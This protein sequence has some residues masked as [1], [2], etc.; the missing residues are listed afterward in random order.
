MTV[1]YGF[2]DSISS[3][4]LYNAKQM[5]SIFDGLIL[6][7][8]Y[9][10]YGNHLKVLENTG[11]TVNVSIGRAWFDHTWTYND[12]LLPKTLVNADALLNRIDIIYLEVNENVGVR[13][14]SINGLTG[15]P[16]SDPVPPDLINTSTIHQY[17][18]A[19]IYVGAGVTQIYQANITD[20]VGT[21]NTPFVA[22]VVQYEDLQEQIYAI[23]GDVN[24]PLI[25]LID[26]KAH[27]HDGSPTVKIPQVPYLIKRQGG[28]A[29]NWNVAGTQPYTPAGVRMQVGSKLGAGAI[30]AGGTTTLNVYFP[31]AFSAIPIVTATVYDP[32]Y[33]SSWGIGIVSIS[34]T[35][36]VIEIRNNT[37]TLLPAPNALWTAIGPE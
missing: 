36:A 14:N 31:V 35:L 23:V 6:D 16:A 20:M 26:L 25:D 18:L 24:P 9:A 37:D 3:D 10:N 19:H 1:T 29:T 32:T 12:A 11:M 30:P 7:G 21:E 28:H 2:Y 15:T 8:V 33:A 27:D 34:T 17:A 22:L 5:G 13:A 4:R